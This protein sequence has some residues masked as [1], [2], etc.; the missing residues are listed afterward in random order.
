MLPVLRGRQVTISET[1]GK[2]RALDSVSVLKEPFVF[3]KESIVVYN[4]DYY[5]HEY[6]S[7]VCICTFSV[8][9]SFQEIGRKSNMR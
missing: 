5:I 8:N 6:M 2:F 7:I 9:H 4:I 1:S 3:D